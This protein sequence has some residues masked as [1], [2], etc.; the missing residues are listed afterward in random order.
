ML[1]R[2]RFGKFP[3]PPLAK[4]AYKPQ[5]FYPGFD[6]ANPAD[7]VGI[8]FL[9]EEEDSARAF[10]SK[11]KNQYLISNGHAEDLLSE[12]NHGC[13]G[14]MGWGGN[15]PGNDRDLDRFHQRPWCEVN[16]GTHTLLSNLLV[17]RHG[18]EHDEDF[19]STFVLT[20]KHQKNHELGKH[21]ARLHAA[22]GNDHVTEA[23]AKKTTL[24]ERELGVMIEDGSLEQSMSEMFKMRVMQEPMGL[25][26]ESPIHQ[27]LKR[28]YE[29]HGSKGK[30]K[31][32]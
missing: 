15:A 1:A 14:P 29:K 30:K 3:Q 28:M 27:D 10:I 2:M 17:N 22:M 7:G 19:I 11:F 24:A 5:P 13:G 12:Q 6:N 32:R 8:P 16:Q 21:V 9:H 18:L 23:E 25:L 31:D 26:E 4:L 20:S